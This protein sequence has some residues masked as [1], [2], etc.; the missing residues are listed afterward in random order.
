MPAITQTTQLKFP[1]TDELNEGIARWISQN[2]NTPEFHEFKLK[3]LGYTLFDEPITNLDDFKFPPEIAKERAVIGAFL[4][5]RRSHITLSQCE[6]YFRRFPFR[7]LPISRDDHLRNIC[8]LYFS[9]FYIIRSRIKSTLTQ[10]REACPNNTVDIG[11]FIKAY[12]KLFRD[13]LRA[14]NR[15]HHEEAFEDLGISRITISDI[16]SRGDDAEHKIWS[17]QHRIAYRKFSKEWSIRAHNQASVMQVMIERV[18]REILSGATF[19]RL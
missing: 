19:L 9:T 2:L 17:W 16:I 18:A 14:R 10:L 3:Q 8:E 11:K 1:H 7:G 15:V 12:D 6:Y 5:L 4:E 13:E